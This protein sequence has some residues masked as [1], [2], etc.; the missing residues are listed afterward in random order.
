MSPTHKRLLNWG[1]S[2]LALTGI[3][4]VALRLKVYWVDLDLSRINWFVGVAVAGLILLYALANLLLVMGW[5]N[6]L[7][8]SGVR[9]TPRWAVRIYGVSQLA[10]YV[11]G[12]IF[13]LAGRQALGIAAGAPN[14]ALAKSTLWE[15]ALIAFAGA[16]YFWLALPIVLP[17]FSLLMSCVCLLISASGT[18]YLLRRFIGVRI[19]ACFVWQWGFLAISGGIFAALVAVIPSDTQ[20]EFSTYMLIAGIFVLAW[21]AGL[22][23][24]GAPAGV[25]VRELILL[26]LLN[27]VVTD[28][29]LLLAIL[30]GRLVTVM[31]DLLFFVV[32]LWI[33]S[34]SYKAN[35]DND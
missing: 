21:L 1:G 33:P 9:T 31:G 25:G 20:R 30:L 12:N 10:K 26:T 7:A 15:F 8:Q 16:Q 3:I 11:P 35:A 5:K 17:D 19:S 22:V 18:A 32:S 23:T 6:L 27:G 29:D 13:H 34:E 28:T 2:G 24:P 4:F 14:R